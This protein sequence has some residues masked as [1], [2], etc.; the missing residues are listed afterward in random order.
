MP[1]DP[2]VRSTEPAEARTVEERLDLIERLCALMVIHGDNMPSFD[3]GPE[4]ARNLLRRIALEV[5]S[6]G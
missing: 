1:A 6:R 3:G 4:G 2:S 5:E